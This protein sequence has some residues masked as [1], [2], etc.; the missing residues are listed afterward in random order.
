MTR[1]WISLAHNW[2]FV[3]CD[4]SGAQ[5]P[6]YDDSWWQTVSVPHCFN[7]E[8]TWIPQRGYYR[9]PAWYRC[10]LP[11]QD[12][13][14]RIELDVLASFAVTDAWL[15]GIHLGS[16][17]GGFTGFTA[18]LTPHLKD[19]NNVLAFRVTNEHDPEVLPGK[20]IP[21]YDLYGGVYREVGLR[22]TSPVHIP[23]RGLIASTPTVN[24]DSGS[25][26]MNVLVRNDSDALFNGVVRACVTDPDG[27]AAGTGSQIF[28]LAAGSERL[29]HVPLPDVNTPKLWSVDDPQLY[30]IDAVIENADG[31]V[32]D[33][34]SVHFGFRWFD[35]DVDKGFFLNGKPLKLK[36]MNRHQDFPGLGNAIPASFQS[37]DVGLLK[38]HGCNYVRCSHYPMHPA[39]L[40]ACDRLGVLVYEEIASWQHVGGELFAR[41][42]Q[43]MMA[44]M[45]AR[46]RHH[47]SIIFWGLLN[48]GRNRDLFQALHNT[49]H[50]HD[51]WRMTVYAE[52]EPAEGLKLGTVQIPDVIGLN[53]KVPHLD[54][55]REQ[56][57]G[58]KLINSE[59]SNANIDER[60]GKEL[61]STSENELWQMEKVLYDINEFSKR[62]WLAGSALWCMH[63]YGT[64]YEPTWPMHESGVFN[65]WRIPK[66]AA[67]GIRARWSTDPFVRILGHWTY[68]GMEKYEIEVVVVSNCNEVELFLNDTSLGAKKSSVDF[69]WSVPYA[70]G[71][72]R[73]VSRP[74]D[75]SEHTHEILTA[76]AARAVKLETLADEL[77]A[78]GTDITLLTA[79][80]VDANGTPIPDAQRIVSFSAELDGVAGGAD[81]FGLAGGY[82]LTT[83][84]GHGRIVLRAGTTPGT[85]K[86]NAISSA[87]KGAELTMQLT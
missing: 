22:I 10:T 47:P 8:D 67:W 60:G 53:Y 68:P 71:T 43:Q 31:E 33:S 9:G 5:D 35:I 30:I 62:E 12:F 87:L 29:V 41:N 79:T 84:N 4:V 24:A 76:G 39:F 45:I 78:N 7:A 51:P 21:D 61:Y 86:I 50:R 28:T 26:H 15:N 83:R 65:G 13:T 69:R 58:I 6:G 75:G 66:A 40:D 16:Y 80:I 77:P 57:V 25:V 42:A 20:D 1:E 34:D 73:A 18:D 49:A 2:R 3:K 46:D 74:G 54:E 64:D 52:N 11:E 63:D 55:L 36:G 23:Q 48:E 44:E 19:G 38:Q 59:H 70:E 32:V 37:Y 17:M 27:T 72:L 82:G 56:L 85:L 14:G 81:F